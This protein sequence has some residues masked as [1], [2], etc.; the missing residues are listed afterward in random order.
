M[1][2]V[3]GWRF[4]I[5]DGDDFASSCTFVSH[6]DKGDQRSTRACLGC[7]FKQPSAS[8][9]ACIA[10]CRS[11]SVEFSSWQIQ[12]ILDYSNSMWAHNAE[13]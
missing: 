2:E 11:I 10:S 1:E 3:V 8:T 12:S 7:V 5:E 9:W 4:H 13:R 6:N